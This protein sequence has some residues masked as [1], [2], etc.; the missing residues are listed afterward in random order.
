MYGNEDFGK[1]SKC[2]GKLQPVYF[3]EKERKVIGGIMTYTGRKRIAVDYLICQDCLRKEC[4]D[5]S[6]DEMWH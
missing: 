3:E 5:D 2:G 4:V 1:C 6:F